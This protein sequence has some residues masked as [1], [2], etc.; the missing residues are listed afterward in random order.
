MKYSII[1]LFCVAFSLLLLLNACEQEEVDAEVF[2]DEDLV[3]YFDL[4]VEEG[5]KRGVAVDLS[6]ISGYIEQITSLS[7]AGNCTRATNTIRIDEVF[8]R[9][10][11]DWEKEYVVFH[12]LGHCYLQRGHKNTFDEATNLCSSI[13]NS[14]NSACDVKYFGKNRAPYLDELFLER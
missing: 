7:V 1:T 12:E 11:P 9:S 2:V 10:Q 13:M 6:E 3:A 8:W 5:A 14:G 4:F